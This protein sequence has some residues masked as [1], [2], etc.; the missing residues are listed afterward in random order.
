MTDVRKTYEGDLR[1]KITILSQNHAQVEWLDPDGTVVWTEQCKPADGI[2]FMSQVQCSGSFAIKPGYFVDANGKNHYVLKCE[3][4]R[5][6]AL[7]P[8]G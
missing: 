6:G 8:K 2:S 3:P 4:G 1:P 5:L 7:F